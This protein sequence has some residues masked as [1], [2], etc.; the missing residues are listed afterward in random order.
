MFKIVIRLDSS[1]SGLSIGFLQIG[2]VQL[3]PCP[4]VPLLDKNACSMQIQDMLVL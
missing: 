2:L 3:G 4:F 1:L